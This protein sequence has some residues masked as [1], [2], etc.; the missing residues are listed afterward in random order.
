MDAD[1]ASLQG[2]NLLEQCSSNCRGT[3]SVHPFG[4]IAA[5]RQYLNTFISMDGVYAEAMLGTLPVPTHLSNPRQT[6][7][8]SG[9]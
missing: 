6:V 4:S 5:L 8:Q 2:G 3:K 7:S 9:V 1:F